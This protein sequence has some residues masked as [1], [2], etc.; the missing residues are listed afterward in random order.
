MKKIF[1]LIALFSLQI[2]CFSQII[3]KKVKDIDIKKITKSDAVADK[4]ISYE[5]SL[6]QFSVA[7]ATR[8]TI[9]NND[10]RSTWGNVRIGF[11]EL[12]ANGQ[13]NL[14][15]RIIAD[16]DEESFF[17]T[18]IGRHAA[19]RSKSFYQD[20]IGNNDNERIKRISVRVSENMVK[21]RRI[22][23]K[24][25][26]QLR[27]AHKDNDFATYDILRMAAPV[28]NIIY[29]EDLPTKEETISVLTNGHSNIVKVA[30]GI[31]EGING[32]NSDDTHRIWL[33][34]TIKKKS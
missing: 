6:D 4:M 31:A 20:R 3:T 17:Y 24:V 29:L 2:V 1:T 30:G 33:H 22:V 26:V 5:I 11:Y 10:C 8:N 28:S 32:G 16:L 14:S 19:H 9:D 7:E 15:K 21:N 27:T 13:I 23:A 12:D 18:M 34:F 25:E